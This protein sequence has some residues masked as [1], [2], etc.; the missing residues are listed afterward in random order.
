M[1]VRCEWCKKK[2]APQ[3]MLMHVSAKHRG[4]VLSRFR[5]SPEVRFFMF[6]E[7]GYFPEDQKMLPAPNPLTV[8]STRPLGKMAA[9]IPQH[10][11][12]KGYQLERGYAQPWQLL[13][14]ALHYNRPIY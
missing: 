6:A 7:R 14:G 1:K 10:R 9:P 3:G 13:A 5:N 8:Y 12:P 11:R 2:I 4:M